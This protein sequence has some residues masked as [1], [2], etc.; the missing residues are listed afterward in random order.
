VCAQ[1]SM[2]MRQWFAP[3]ATRIERAPALKSSSAGC[4]NTQK[5]K[6]PE[7]VG[8]HEQRILAPVREEGTVCGRRPLAGSAHG[9]KPDRL[10]QCSVRSPPACNECR[11]A[12]SLDGPSS[13]TGPGFQIGIAD[14]QAITSFAA[15]VGLPRLVIVIILLCAAPSPA[16]RL[17]KGEYCI[18]SLPSRWRCRNLARFRDECSISTKVHFTHIGGLSSSNSGRQ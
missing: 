5:K 16:I 17:T 18:F 1:V 13:T 3:A 10:A 7:K 15:L 8:A 14:A 4:R 11:G 2:T 6:P 12:Q 9:V